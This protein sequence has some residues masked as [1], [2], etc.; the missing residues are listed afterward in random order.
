M[1]HKYNFYYLLSKSFLVM[2][3]WKDIYLNVVRM[4]S[5]H[6]RGKPFLHIHES[7][8]H[9]NTSVQHDTISFRRYFTIQNNQLFYQHKFK[10]ILKKLK[11][12]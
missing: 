12:K 3:F 9:I 10:V 7:L 5:R 11:I 1:A 2:L 6:G 8:S 4:H